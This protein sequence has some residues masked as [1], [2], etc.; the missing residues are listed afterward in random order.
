MLTGCNSLAVTGAPLVPTGLRDRNPGGAS[1][2]EASVPTCVNS[3]VE[4]YAGTRGE[5]KKTLEKT[6]G[7]RAREKKKENYHIADER[8]K[9]DPVGD[10][11]GEEVQPK[12]RPGGS[13]TTGEALD[14]E[15]STK[16]KREEDNANTARH[17][18][19]EHGGTA[20]G[21]STRLTDDRVSVETAARV[22][23]AGL[24]CW[25]YLEHGPGTTAPGEK[26]VME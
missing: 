2:V 24:M 11:D 18:N 21:K 10:E 15:H 22:V 5:D 14:P 17:R 6:R 8:T 19:S 25:K 7:E 12:D 20:A 26:S 3:K 13:K 1:E 23:S 4:G 16:D 9:N